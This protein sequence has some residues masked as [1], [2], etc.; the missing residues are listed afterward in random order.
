ME[1]DF[2]VN[3]A[4]DDIG[5]GLGFDSTET[6][7]DDDVQLDVEAPKPE[8]S[9]ETPEAPTNPSTDTPA[10][11]TPTA[12][13]APKTWRKEA[14]A[15]WAALPSEAKA[16][17]LKR[18]NDIF[19]GIEAMK[20]DAQYGKAFKSVLA[21]YAEILRANN[22]EPVATV[23]NLL[24]AHHL[25]ATGTPEAKL[26]LFQKMARD[27]NIPLTPP[28]EAPYI[29]P[30]VAALQSELNAV[31]SQLSQTSQR[32]QQVAA[33]E[34]SQ[35]VNA[36]ASDAKNIYFNEVADDIAVM[37]SRGVAKD[38]ADAYEK[39]VW[40]NPVTRAKEIAR[41]TAEASAKAAEEAKAKAAIVRK[42]TAANVTAR[43]RSG[44]AAIPLGSLDDTLEAQ[45]ARI[46]A[47]A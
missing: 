47:R 25:F 23:N 21:P 32:Q 14:S 12:D 45:L 29:D 15:T 31:K 18:E 11:P 3:A 8:A 36:F 20:P 4:V 16:E 10:T 17:I 26:Q 24:Q 19:Q 35:Q 22:M 34:V 9:T 5:A 30:T 46:K 33:Q 41:T 6:K 27:Y 1:D 40:A 28:G 2:D 43:A 13:E 44:N 37:I 39:A 38:L 42:A 7:E